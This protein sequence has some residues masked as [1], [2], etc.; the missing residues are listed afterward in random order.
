MV[1]KKTNKDYRRTY[2]QKKGDLHKANDVARKKTERERRKHLEPK[3]VCSFQEER[4]CRC[5][6]YRLK[7]DFRAIIGQHCNVNLRN[8]PNH[9]FSIFNKSNFEPI[10]H[11]TKRSLSSS[12]RKKAEVIGTLAKKFN[13]RIAVHNKSGRKKNELSEEKKNGLR[14]F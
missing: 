6:E 2:C 13:L 4:S 11:K 10:F 9:V 1:N 5:Q 7:K 14:T 3:K 12:P 8:N